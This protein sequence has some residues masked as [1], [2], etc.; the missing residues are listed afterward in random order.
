[1]ER[2]LT[3]AVQAGA[4]LLV[5][6]VAYAISSQAPARA[7]SADFKLKKNVKLSKPPS[8]TITY[9]PDRCVLLDGGIHA[10]ALLDDDQLDKG[11]RLD[12]K[13]AE[14][15]RM[16]VGKL[17]TATTK[18]GGKPVVKN[19]SVLILAREIEPGR[20]VLTAGKETVRVFVVKA[21]DRGSAP[22]DWPTYE[23]HPPTSAGEPLKCGLCHEKST[24]GEATVLGPAEEPGVCFKCHDQDAYLLAHFP[25][26]LETFSA[27]GY[28]HHPHGATRKKLLVEDVETMCVRCHEL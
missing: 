22:K 2:P 25:H 15:K 16:P 11:L 27:C 17:G 12:G 5:I 26:R 24:K 20:H 9:P 14:T 7:E 28:C 8:K 3:R 1:M 23:P 4:G 10:V 6:T 21:M 19:R 13:P 18:P